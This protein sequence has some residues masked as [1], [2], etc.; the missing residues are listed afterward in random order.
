[1]IQAVITSA[2]FLIAAM[3]TGLVRHY[4]L[5]RSVLDIPNHRSSHT[6]PTP[7]GGGVAIV[8]AFATGIVALWALERLSPHLAIALLGGGGIV[9]LVG[10]VDDHRHLPAL[11]RLCAHFVAAAWVLAWLGGLP[12]VPFAGAERDLGPVG[13][14]L[15]AVALVWMLNLYNF[16]DGIDGIA[17]VETVAVCAG[18]ILLSMVSPLTTGP[19][20]LLL[21]LVAATFGFLAW[22]FPPARIFMGDAGSGFLGIVLGAFALDAAHREPTWLWSWI[23]LLAVFIADATITLLFRLRRGDRLY[24]AHRTHAYQHATQ[25]FGSHLPVSLAV[26]VITLGWLLP[27]AVLVGSGRVSGA[28]G[29]IIAYLPMVALVLYFRAGRPVPD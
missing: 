5:A 26:G 11:W 28:T 13:D 14:L 17:A 12:P 2:V 6:V 21:L 24:E 22:N 3:G 29:T 9:A 1:M 19:W 27:W 8:I 25:R 15:A 4:A 23:I 20:Q 16:M 10:F 18:A 7:R